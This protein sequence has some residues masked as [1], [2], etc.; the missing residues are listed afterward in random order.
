MNKIFFI[1]LFGLLL[2]GPRFVLAAEDWSITNFHSDIAVQK[3]ASI[4]VHETIDVNFSGAHHGIFRDLP[5][6]ATFNG[7]TSTLPISN[8]TV[9]QDGSP[10]IFTTSKNQKQLRIKIGDPEFTIT[11]VHAYDI[12]YRVAAAVNFFSDF[13]ELNWNVTGNDWE[14][15]ITKSSAT[16][17]LPDSTVTPTT[18]CYT[19]PK[20]S[21]AQ[22]CAGVASAGE[23]RYTA[24]DTL[25]IVSHWQK[26]VVTKPLSYDQD[27]RVSMM[28]NVLW[29]GSWVVSIL[30]VLGTFVFMYRRWS[31]IGKDPEEPK[32]VI[33]QYEPP[34]GLLPAEA[35]VVSG[36]T[37]SSKAVTATIIDLA[38]RGYLRIEEREQ[39]NI[40]SKKKDFALLIV[41]QPDD[42]LR[43]YEKS[44]F[45]ML[46]SS[47]AKDDSGT[48]LLSVMKKHV[49][50]IAE[51]IQEV[52]SQISEGVNT[53]G[54]FVGNPVKTVATYSIISSL[55]LIIPAAI[56]GDM[57]SSL[58]GWA[59]VLLFG[60]VGA[61][62]SVGGFGLFMSRR[63]ETGAKAHWQLKGFKLYLTTAEKYRVQWQEDN[64]IFE[65]FL[66]YAV[67]FGVADKWAKTFADISL[68]RPDW[69][70]GSG[71]WNS[72]YALHALNSFSTSFSSSTVPSSGGSSAGSGGGGG[73]GGGGSW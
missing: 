17:H 13:D 1:A 50:D 59:I 66:P 28:D 22:D 34:T 18:L 53:R 39:Q 67:A 48:A 26:G 57:F 54:Y 73:G 55:M 27:R 35:T 64:H 61:G 30:I 33:A 19:G 63:S 12:T 71:N 20:G 56:L 21:T 72:L 41:K 15:P 10:A 70:S 14:V 8:I 58:P 16:M 36:N 4:I 65:K 11:D 32:T 46:Q 37:V 47:E 6:T 68:P 25:T 62:C 23:A 2:G 49:S 7:K 45:A 38:V 9:Q 42:S 40:F 5:L 52:R 3:D 69:Y 29:Y 43:D 51:S 24:K 60:L 31:K 44:I